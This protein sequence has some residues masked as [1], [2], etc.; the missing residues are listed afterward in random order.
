MCLFKI[1]I[2]VKCKVPYSK[3]DSADKDTNPVGSYTY[4]VTAETEAG[5]IDLAF[6]NFHNTI[7]ISNLEHF[8]MDL[9]KVIRIPQS[10]LFIQSLTGSKT[11]KSEIELNY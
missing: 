6:Y 11:W 2:K 4:E 7:P 9:K 5:A 10:I 8:S 3:M 1:T